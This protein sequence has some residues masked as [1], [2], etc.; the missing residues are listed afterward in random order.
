MV[1]LLGASA[2]AATPAELAGWWRFSIAIS[3]EHEHRFAVELKP[4]EGGKFTGRSREGALAE[5]IGGLNTFM[6]ERMMGRVLSGG[7]GFHVFDGTAEATGEGWTLRGTTASPITGEMA[8]V[9]KFAGGNAWEGDLLGREGQRMG[10]LQAT[11]LPNPTAALRDYPTVWRAMSATLRQY[12]HDP[13]LLERGPLADLLKDAEATAPKLKDDV[14]VQLRVVNLQRELQ[15]LPIQLAPPPPPT[16]PGLTRPARNDFSITRPREGVA[17][18]RAAS[19]GLGVEAAALRA[20][21]AELMS[22]SPTRGL[23]LDFRGTRGADTAGLALL[24]GL[25]TEP[26]RLGAYFR[27]GWSAANRGARPS[28]VHAVRAPVFPYADVNALRLRALGRDEQGPPA[29]AIGLQVAPIADTALRYSGPLWILTSE[30]TLGLAEMMAHHLRQKRQAKIVGE[31]TRG[32]L[33]LAERLPI[34]GGWRLTL[35]I[36]DYVAADGAR[37]QGEGVKPDLKAKA[38]EALDRALAQIR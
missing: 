15:I 17:V 34:A 33:V 8:L 4:A 16:S 13:A 35:P 38:D 32:V 25:L 37:L 24:E 12:L 28:A 1:A 29:L 36:A 20:T 18:L 2:A 14:D 31:E 21:W 27:P 19:L 11:R 23:V 7:A 6:G 5:A 3:G 26:Q 10:R 9:A 22:Q 30:R